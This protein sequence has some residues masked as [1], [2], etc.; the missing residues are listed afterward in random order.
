MSFF[1]RL[2]AVALAA[3]LTGTGMP[4]QARTRQGDKDFAQGRA[5]EEKK[6]WDKA[7]DA[8]RKA[9]AADPSD[10]QYQMATQKARFQASQLHVENGDKIRGQGMLGE[11]LL[12]F[13]RAFAIDPGSTIAVQE[14]RT[15][16]EMIERE[17]QRIMQTGKESTP[18]EKGLT[19]LQQMQRAT[20]ER[21]DR[22]LPVPELRPLGPSR[23]DLQI[24]SN[25][26]KTLFET[27]GAF[28]GINVLWD[29][30]MQPANTTPIKNGSV[31]FQN[32]TL[33][34]ALDYLAVLT[35]SFW[36]PLSANTIFVTSDTR[37]K[38]T[39][40]A[41]QVL[42]VFYISNVQQQQDLAE[43]MNAVRT[44]C[45]IQ[46][47]FAINSQNAIVAR[48]DADQIALVEKIIHDLD[49]PKSEV[50][51]DI[52]V[53][54]T[55]SNYS[56]QLAAALMPTG[57]NMSGAFT[58]TNGLQVSTSSS[59]S[60]SSTTTST[61][62]ATTTTP[63]TT[64]PTT[65]TGTSIPISSLGHLTSADWS[66]TLPSGLLQ[67]V[68][69]DADT[70]I[71]QAPQLRSM[72]NLK[73][74][75]KI[76]EREPTAS[77]SFGSTLGS[78]GVGVSPLVQT[79]FTYLEIGV[80]V[81]ITPR[82][83]DNGDVSMHVDLEISSVDGYVNLG[84]LSEPII[85]QKKV[86]NDIRLREGEV[87]LLGGL[88][89]VEQDTTKT[90]VPGLAD[91]PLLGRLF[92]SD[93]ITKTR[94]ELMIALVP[95]V[96]RRPVFSAENLRTI[97]VGTAN[98]IH[99]NYAPRADEGGSA[100]AGQAAPEA[101]TVLTPAPPPAAP[102][103]PV[104]PVAAPMTQ[105]PAAPPAAPGAPP[106]TPGAP[107]GLPFPLQQLMRPRPLGPTPPAPPGAE[108]ATPPASP[109]PPPGTASA[110][111]PGTASAALSGAATDAATPP[112]N[113]T[114]RFEPA[115][116]ETSANGAFSA[117]LVL[118]AGA[119]VVSAQPLQIKYDPKLLRL[120]D[121]S[122]GDLF[123]RDGVAPV[124]ARDIQNDQGLAT[125]RIGRQPGASGVNAPGT[126]L[127]LKFQAIAPGDTAVSV[128][129]V[130]VRNSQA[131]A[132][133]SSSPQLAVSIK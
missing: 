9:L 96:V 133:G 91:I 10:L 117:A 118:D 52:I 101:G 65:T 54:Q 42:K 115:R 22:I 49:R 27:L 89:D 106:A 11:A 104:T 84:G 75:M 44:V 92:R 26:P 124:F 14:V 123:S 13:Q 111:P 5:F 125:I 36:K 74:T 45:D 112:G 8:Y 100:P 66:T 97:D 16:Q 18:E 21:L 28:A 83:H 71:L 46:R 70:E 77:G 19:P 85:A 64:T 47:M 99:L 41:D 113:A 59:S 24:N 127:T 32:S 61:T 39:D 128:L 31:K 105:S 108:P 15:T 103:G 67:A 4:L 60:S 88:I 121:V 110:A 87:N 116:F 107:P 120:T 2:T 30:D 81:E 78:V 23:F 94:S 90:G 119:D 98:A 25:I 51:V 12:E 1:N 122:A 93:S 126:L 68:M 109:A 76:G 62:G 102:P 58:P 79:Q 50:V 43:I 35:K 80:N 82:I 3:M 132:V 7:L 72:D 17:R 131:R 73:A 33:N 56:R 37:A 40:Y 69:S 129:N 57:L 34:E 6:E 86:I 29:S 20:D 53:M 63:T 38:R 55:S 48:G 95:H 114:A 130:T